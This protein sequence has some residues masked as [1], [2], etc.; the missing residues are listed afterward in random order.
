MQQA[1]CL[2]VAFCFFG[3]PAGDNTFLQVANKALAGAYGPL[4][5][6]Q[7]QAYKKG[8]QM[9]LAPI[10]RVVLTTYY[11]SEGRSGRVDC[12]GQP[13]GP[14]AA[15]ANR[16]PQGWC[17]WTPLTGLRRIRDRGAPSNDRKAAR[18]NALWVDIWMPSKRQARQQGL[19]GW[20]LT[21]AA[22]IPR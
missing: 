19:D 2:M 18:Y 15:S 20:K 16:I 10:H 8:I 3:G 1:I 4:Q 7:E 22:I 12:H 14:D 17:I 11:P 13:L 21:Q 9:H 5:P 6:W